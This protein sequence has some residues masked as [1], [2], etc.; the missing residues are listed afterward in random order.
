[1]A[2]LNKD[3]NPA[4]KTGTLEPHRHLI[5]YTKATLRLWGVGAGCTGVHG[6]GVAFFFLL[7]MKVY[8]CFLIFNLY[9]LTASRIL[10]L[11]LL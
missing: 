8:L 9:Q 2:T 10:V 5:L 6:A 1:M 3:F 4:G 7:Y 11:L